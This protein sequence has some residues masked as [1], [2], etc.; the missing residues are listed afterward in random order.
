MNLQGQPSRIEVESLIL[1]LE[2]HRVWRGSV[3]FHLSATEF[4][5][6]FLLASNPGKVVTRSRILSYVWEYSF[7]GDSN[8]I[9]SVIS[10]IRKKVD[11]MGPRLIHT[12]REVGYSIRVPE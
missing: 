3:E 4:K 8:I 9:E 7:D 1:D 6:L 5:L 2:S 11:S 10:N 12:V